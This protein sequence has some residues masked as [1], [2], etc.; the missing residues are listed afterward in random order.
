MGL[1]E[2]RQVKF[3][4]VYQKLRDSC[5]TENQLNR[6]HIALEN[7]MTPSERKA[8][9]LFLESEYSRPQRSF[10][11]LHSAIH[12]RLPRLGLGNFPK[13]HW[14]KRAEWGWLRKLISWRQM[15]ADHVL[16][17]RFERIVSTRG[18]AL[19]RRTDLLRRSLLIGF[20]GSSR[21]IMMSPAD[22]LGQLSAFDAD[23]LLLWPTRGGG[24][25]SGV[26]G[27]GSDIPMVGRAIQ[28]LIADWDYNDVRM[29]GTSAG[30]LPA[31]YVASMLQPV[32]VATIGTSNPRGAGQYIPWLEVSENL[33][34]LIDR[35]RLSFTYGGNS[36]RDEAVA[37]ALASEVGGIV[38]EVDGSGHAP[39]FDLLRRGELSE[40]LRKN[41]F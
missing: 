7:R 8:V 1:R 27:L 38:V 15:E 12:S 6:L 28:E 9:I 16:A 20:S 11:R 33:G 2:G 4:R 40:W 26:P 14:R 22:F 30:S 5:I 17:E 41:L 37:K 31:L 29:I 23:L 3:I 32:T 19:Y 36:R 39:L 34:H 35:M 18:Y 13:S 10:L 25:R 21:R 24:Y